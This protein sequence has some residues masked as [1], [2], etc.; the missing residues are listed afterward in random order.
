MKNEIYE[1]KKL[2]ELSK[3]IEKKLEEKKNSSFF[4]KVKNYFSSK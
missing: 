4:Q 2:K 1:P 3:K